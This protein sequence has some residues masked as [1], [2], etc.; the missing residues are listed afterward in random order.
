MASTPRAYWLAKKAQVGDNADGVGEFTSDAK[1][2]IPEAAPRDEEG[3]HCYMYSQ[4]R[5]A[6]Q[7]RDARLQ[8][9]R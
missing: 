2:H 3:G 5:G 4:T 9:R 6:E 8:Q 7:L 1:N